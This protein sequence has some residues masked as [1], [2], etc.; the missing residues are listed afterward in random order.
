MNDISLYE[1]IPEIE[2]SY[3]IKIRMYEADTLLPHWHEHLEM[4]YILDGGAN[5]RCNSESF[6]V[7]SGETAVIN[8]NEL[9]SFTSQSPMKYLCIIINPSFFSYVKF[10]TLILKSVIPRDECVHSYF[11]EIYRAYSEHGRGDDMSILGYTYCLM[12][13][14]VKNYTLAELTEPEYKSRMIR[15]NK[16]NSVTDYI[17]E[18][19]NEPL[20]TAALAEHFYMSKSHLCRIFKDA[21]GKTPVRY[22]NEFR[23]KKAC[24]LLSGT[25][26]RISDIA[27][28]TGFESL[29]YFDRIFKKQIGVSP[30]NFKNPNKPQIL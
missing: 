10:D 28:K 26:E 2:N 8:R 17:H 23:I 3:P 18:H 16:I 24:V 9:H 14:L 6:E 19:Y 27:A 12:S 22:L 20:S 5:I 7:Q 11:S 21:T 29:Y 4:L 15:L 1:K 13:H 30:L 25:N